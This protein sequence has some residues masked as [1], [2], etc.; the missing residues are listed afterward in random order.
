MP[1]P[2]PQPRNRLADVRAWSGRQA[3]RVRSGV[4]A[5]WSTVRRWKWR[6]IGIWTGGVFGVLA[7]TLVLL[8]TFADWNA[9]RGPIGR[10]AS[11]ATG[12][13]IVIRGDLDVDPW[14]F[15]PD[16]R[17]RDLYVGNPHVYRERGAFA[18]VAEADVSVRLLPLLIG[19]LDFVRIDLRG[20]DI[21]LY[22]SEEGV[23]NWAPSRAATGRPFDLPAIREFSLSDGHIRYEDDK[24]GL[25]LDAEFTTQES[26]EPRNPGR[27]ALMGEGQINNRTFEVEL[28]G[29]PLLNVRRGRPYP[30]V[31]DVRAGGTRIQADGSITRPFNFSRW[32]A[33]IQASGPDLADLYTLIGLAL[34]NTPPYNLSGV[35][36]RNGS[37][38]GMPRVAGRVGD[39]DL[40]GE[41]TAS[42]QRNDRLLLEGAFVSNALDFDD[43]LTVLGAPPSTASG[44]TA[45][46]EQR[47]MAANL[48]AQGRLLP[49]AQL[50]ISRVRN[51]D[52]RVS[53]HAERVAS[54]S[55]PLRA[56]SLD[57]VLD[58]GLLSLDPL[59]IDLTRGRVGGAVAINARDETPRVDLDVRLSNARLESFLRVG[60]QQP[61][62]GSLVGRMQLSGSG[63]S[64]RDAAA[65]AN[66]RISLVTPSGEVREAFAELTGINVTRGL[67]LLLTDS[68][69]T[70]PIRCGVASF[71]VRNGVAHVRS[72]VFD[73][74]TMLIRGG[75]T[76]SLRNETLDL[77]I[78]GEPK[79]PRLIRVAAP[80]TV[81]GRWRTPR[82]GVDADNILGQGGLAA[83]LGSFIAP[84]AAILP[85]VD[86]GLA[87]DA[88]CAAL[89]A[90]RETERRE[91]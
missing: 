68:D 2:S 34:P 31:A 38:Y 75:G 39:S 63:A 67:G 9:L 26:A 40:R 59:T 3:A 89:L 7:T 85:F 51:M 42:R 73:T 10:M 8:V 33:E 56:L 45:S 25:V 44:E 82:V 52:A 76:V 61:L 48:S 6:R 87:D 29:A 12:R 17:V 30:F 24:R 19:R 37:T 54:E 47:Q 80:I 74:E 58:N 16:I 1:D 88:N 69:D 53:F 14:S 77:D 50:D 5:G 15:T 27:F 46:A 11:A 90:G 41:F 55:L 18:Q 36:E 71:D 35:L 70:I 32:S 60:D 28:I 79:E 64:V 86:A 43:V 23:S 22:R 66:G 49:D 78:E 21:A 62:T 91:G 72:M 81:E 84:V 4:S 83:A 20:T 57:I 65:N 13:E